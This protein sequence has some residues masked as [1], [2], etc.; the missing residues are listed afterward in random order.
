MAI[1]TVI[2]HLG[3]AEAKA[4]FSQLIDR[5]ARGERFVIDR[6]GRPVLGLVPAAE[7]SIANAPAGLVSIVGALADWDAL[8]QVIEEI[9]AARLNAE[10]RPVPDLG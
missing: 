8:P 3:V 7:A 2:E 10:D 1:K 4:S 5:V 6:R 9:Y